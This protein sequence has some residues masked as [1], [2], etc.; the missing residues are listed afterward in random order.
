MSDPGP[1]PPSA[2][3]GRLYLL[4]ALESVPDPSVEEPKESAEDGLDQADGLDLASAL[5]VSPASFRDKPGGATNY[6]ERWLRTVPRDE[7][8]RRLKMMMASSRMRP[9]SN[10]PT[11]VLDKAAAVSSR[12]GGGDGCGRRR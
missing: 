11:A 6:G 2:S 4:A 8:G 3:V 5:V 7:R 9:A 1:T 10:S 12:G